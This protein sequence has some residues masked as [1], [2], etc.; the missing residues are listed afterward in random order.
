MDFESKAAHR[1]SRAAW[2]PQTAAKSDNPYA[3]AS[4]STRTGDNNNSNIYN[5]NNSGKNKS[6][7]NNGSYDINNNMLSIPNPYGAGDTSRKHTRRLSIHASAVAHANGKSFSQNA[8]PIDFKKAPPLPSLPKL[9]QKDAGAVS[10]E[11]DHELNIEEKIFNDLANGSAAEID[12]YYKLLTKQ[13]AIITRDIKENIN[14]NQK[15]I[16]LL[17][18]DLKDIQDELLQLRISTKELYDVLDYF[19]ETAKRR[20]DLELEPQQQQ[21]Q[22]PVKSLAIPL[23]KRRD[24]SSILVLEKMWA[25]ELQS[26]FKHVEG[27]SKFVQALPGRHVL[28]ESGRW[29]EVNVG[30]W[31]PTHLA[32]LFVLNDLLLIA[33]KKALQD[34]GGSKSRLQAIQCWPLNQ[35]QLSEIRAPSTLHKQDDTKVYLINIKSKSLS[36]VYQTDRYDHYLKITEAFNKGKNELVQKDRLMNAGRSSITPDASDSKEENKQLRESLRNSGVYE[37]IVDETG[38]RLSGSHRGSAEIVLQDISARVHSRNRSHDF[39]PYKFGTEKGHFFNDIKQLESRLDDVDIEISHN[40][41]AQAVGLI[42]HIEGKLR[43]IETTLIR[44]KGNVNDISDELLLID[45]TKLKLSHRKES[46]QKSLVFDLQHNIAKLTDDKIESIITYF[47]SFNQL[48]KGVESYLSAMSSH[49]AST[50]SR[51]IVGVQGSTKIDVV[52]YL[53]NLV[54]IHIS[55]I[56]R[57][58]IVYNKRISAILKKHKDGNVDSSGLINWCVEEITKLVSEL[59][60]HLYG[61]LLTTTGSDPELD[62]AVYKVKDPRLYDDLLGVIIPQLNELKAVGVNVDFVFEEIL[63][64][65]ESR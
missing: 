57:A 19:K 61:T 39:G 65:Q 3:R 5:T 26:L 60:K 37:S 55:I 31:K 13:K 1:K 18:N 36:Y 56:K 54:V 16:L 46:V 62:R 2:Q 45:V 32:H 64:L 52:N 17:T 35:V 58:V 6:S 44:N 49:L 42:A 12:D 24:R 48:D 53:S 30:T 38:K 25:S 27:A 51:L 43:A 15:N 28:A 33:G 9:V 21:A 29:Q 59:K 50:V 11:K 4:S 22:S 7:G 10:D 20:L 8:P 41:Y 40:Q 23:N 63:S 14:Q 47:E 34:G